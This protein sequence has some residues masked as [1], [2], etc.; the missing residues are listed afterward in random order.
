MS[1]LPGLEIETRYSLQ[2]NTVCLNGDLNFPFF[3]SIANFWVEFLIETL[4]RDRDLKRLTRCHMASEMLNF[5]S[6][7]ELVTNFLCN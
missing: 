2:R 3:P 4:Y 1:L 5:Y 7:Y 6:T